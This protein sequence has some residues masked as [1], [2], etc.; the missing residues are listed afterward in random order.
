MTGNI[1][2]LLASYQFALP[3]ENIAQY[4]LAQRDS[5]RLL[6]VDCLTAETRDR[7]F[8]DICDYLAPGDILVINNTRVFPARLLGRK[9]TGGKAELLI[10]EYPVPEAGSVNG[11][12]D[13]WQK[14]IVIGLV[15][16]AKRPQPGGR[17]F[18][19]ENLAGTVQELLPDGKVRVVLHYRGDL[20][21]ILEEHGQMPLPP[22]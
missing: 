9:E 15:K 21:G 14:A 19:S 4:P 22:Y 2:F 16:S 6:V 20:A 11:E 7:K 8:V 13:G 12:S 17:L 5:S 10:L 1:D 18:F 3:E